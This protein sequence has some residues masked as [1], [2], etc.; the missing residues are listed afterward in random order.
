MLHGRWTADRKEQLNDVSRVETRATLKRKV[1]QLFSTRSEL[2]MK[3]V[4]MYD[5]FFENDY[6]L[7][8]IQTVS[9]VWISLRRFYTILHLLHNFP[10]YYFGTYFNTDRIYSPSLR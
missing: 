5:F 6:T 7:V 3:A 10:Y 9:F 4:I 1:F 2:K 8:E